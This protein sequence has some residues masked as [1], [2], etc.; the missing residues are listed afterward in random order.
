MFGADY[1]VDTSL[2]NVSAGCL[3][4][5]SMQI[6]VLAGATLDNGATMDACTAAQPACQFSQQQQK[7]R[8]TLK[9]PAPDAARMSSCPGLLSSRCSDLFTLMLPCDDRLGGKLQA[10]VKVGANATKADGQPVALQWLLTD[11]LT[12]ALMISTPPNAV[13][14]ADPAAQPPGVAPSGPAILIP[15]KSIVKRLRSGKQ[16]YIAS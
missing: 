11:G 1:A 15:I 12:S 14:V 8:W 6:A 10:R 3:T 2:L 16:Y 5:P 7:L 9:V 4:P 13:A